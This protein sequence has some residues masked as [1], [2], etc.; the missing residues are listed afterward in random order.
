MV[1]AT[2]LRDLRLGV[3]G[4]WIAFAGQAIIL[5]SICAFNENLRTLVAVLTPHDRIRVD[6]LH[7]VAPSV[8]RLPPAGA[9]R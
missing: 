2:G 5:I 3:R 9:A 4:G 7:F 6:G 1:R 8:E